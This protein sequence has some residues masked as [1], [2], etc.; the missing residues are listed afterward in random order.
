MSIRIR[1]RHFFGLSI[2]AVFLGAVGV[3][4]LPLEG[5][6]AGHFYEVL[7]NP[8]VSPWNAANSWNAA[9]A[10]A[11][12]ST[13]NGVSGHLATLTSMAEDV[14][15]D[16]LRFAGG[17]GEVWVGGSQSP[18]VNGGAWTWVNGEGLITT[19]YWH[20]GEPNGGSSENHLAIGL[21]GGN[22][23]GDWNDE[24][25]NNITGYVVEYDAPTE[26]VI[27]A[28]DCSVSQAGCETIPGGGQT[29]TFPEGSIPAG[30]T[31]A[32]TVNEIS[33]QRICAGGTDANGPLT[34]FGGD[35][36][37]DNELIIPEYLCGSPDFVVVKIDSSE[38]LIDEGT[39][40]VENDTAAVLPGNLF[41]CEE[42]IVQDP[43]NNDP[44]HQ[45]VVVWQSTN[46]SEMRENGKVGGTVF[47]GTAGEFTHECGSSR[48]RT[49]G[50][51][52]F[53]V[54]MHIDFGIDWFGGD[55]DNAEFIALT[56]YKLTLLAESVED[57]RSEGALTKKG[58]YK[59]MRNMVANAINNLDGGNFDDALDHAQNFVKFVDRA[60]YTTKP[61]NY[62][63]E[64]LMRG[65]NIEFMLRV[66]IIPFAS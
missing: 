35:G 63:G 66:K 55:R 29:V 47:E 56:R 21:W 62:N 8:I 32:V 6:D 13:H 41:I 61:V 16:Q 49:M 10:A 14:F 30:A 26:V 43:P 46:P 2:F 5:P 19:F 9:K 27:P 17:F 38:L 7:P 65:L 50:A 11:E 18:S 20:S 22:N 48:A 42:P 39:V 53:V 64:H 28:E 54:G 24:G 34:L 58:D 12:A 33:D 52:Y 31:I 60:S 23:G 59:K 40:F 36:I 15:V 3:N 57:A 25:N 44:Q 4:A 1:I 51:S 37:P 45:D